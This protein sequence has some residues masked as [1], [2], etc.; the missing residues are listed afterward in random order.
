M[1]MGCGLEEIVGMAMVG[2]RD[3]AGALLLCSLSFNVKKVLS[4]LLAPLQGAAQSR[5]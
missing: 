2:R 4:T 5:A 1:W 3:G